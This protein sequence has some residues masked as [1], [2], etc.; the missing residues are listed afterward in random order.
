MKR[1]SLVFCFVFSLILFSFAAVA[2][3]DDASDSQPITDNSG[4]GS[5]S[6]SLSYRQAEQAQVDPNHVFDGTQPTTD[7]KATFTPDVPD[8]GEGAPVSTD[9]DQGNVPQDADS[10]SQQQAQ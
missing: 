1:G 3:A 4:S 9:S 2:G 10:G 6:D 5:V 8:A 7:E